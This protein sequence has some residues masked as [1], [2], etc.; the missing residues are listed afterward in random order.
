MSAYD[1]LE[2]IAKDLREA[3]ITAPKNVSVPLTQA[4]EY[5]AE[6]IERIDASRTQA[7][8]EANAKL[9]D[10]ANE[11][12]KDARRKVAVEEIFEHC[13]CMVDEEKGFLEAIIKAAQR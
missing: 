2:K 4:L 7:L 13:D 6:R 10:S 9:G 8:A 1:S 5:I 11:A 3:K 12:E